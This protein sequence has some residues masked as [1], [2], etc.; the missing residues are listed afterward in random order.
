MTSTSLL[1]LGNVLYDQEERGGGRERGG[2]MEEGREREGGGW[3]KEGREGE[4]ELEK[5][6]IYNVNEL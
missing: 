5:G 1:F 6:Y 2:G 3:G 4:R